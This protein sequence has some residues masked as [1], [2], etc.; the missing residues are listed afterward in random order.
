MSDNIRVISIVD[1]FL[2]HS[3][4]FYFHNGG[5][6][7]Y[8][9]SSADWMP[10]NLHRRIELMFPLSRTTRTRPPSARFSTS[11]S[12]TQSRR[13]SCSPDGSYRRVRGKKPLRSQEELYRRARRR[14]EESLERPA[15]GGLR[16]V[17]RKAEPRRPPGVVRRRTASCERTGVLLMSQASPSLSAS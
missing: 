6:E 13:A 16:F 15:D 1:R 11:S 17:P 4:I 10:R 5:Q 3:R 9:L 2:E 8:Y 14:Y 12:P 7:E